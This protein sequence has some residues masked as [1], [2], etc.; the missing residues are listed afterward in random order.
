MPQRRSG[1]GG[2]DDPRTPEGDAVP[3]PPGLQAD[4]RAWLLQTVSELQKTTSRLEEAVKTLEKHVD[5]QGNQIETTARDV[6]TATVT[7]SVVSGGFLLIM[8]VLYFVV[9]HAWAIRLLQ[10]VLQG[11]APVKP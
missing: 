1:R 2:P 9:D 7:V 8:G 5:K 3:T 10:A 4:D 6:H 11:L